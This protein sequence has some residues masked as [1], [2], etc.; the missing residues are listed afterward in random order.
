M[1]LNSKQKELLDKLDLQKEPFESAR[2]VGCAEDFDFD[3]LEEDETIYEY[4]GNKY[5]ISIDDQEMWEIE[6]EVMEKFLTQ[7]QIE[8]L[9]VYLIN[10]GKDTGKYR[11]GL[12]CPEVIGEE[13]STDFSILEF[14]GISKKLEEF[15]FND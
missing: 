5:W 9:E 1:P 3:D 2:E 10:E 14:Y 7:K 6:E 8:E 4:K 11:L 13:P 12:L 15:V